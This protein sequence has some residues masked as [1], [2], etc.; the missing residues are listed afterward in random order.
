MKRR[1]RMVLIIAVTVIIPVLYVAYR[2]VVP[3]GLG[4][5]RQIVPFLFFS[6]DRGTY[7]SPDG[8]CS[9]SVYSNDAGAAHSGFFPSWVVRRHWW[10]REV[11][12]KGYLKSSTGGV[13]LTWRGRC[14]FQILFTQGPY[15][16]TEKPVEVSSD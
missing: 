2:H 12:A 6:T 1:R 15:D 14:R 5:S 13:P 3:I 10:G 11:A 16:D 7:D 8:S 9:V 4:G